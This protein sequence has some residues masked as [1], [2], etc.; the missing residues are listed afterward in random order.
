M[1][2]KCTDPVCGHHHA[3]P[4]EKGKAKWILRELGAHLPYTMFSAIA[5]LIL[6]AVLTSAGLVGHLLTFFH[7]FHPTHLFLS[8]TTTT[9]IFW[10]RGKPGR[11]NIIEA[12][13]IG[14]I[15][16][17]PFCT[18]SDI[19]FPY[20]AGRILHHQM[21]WHLC[22]VE[23]FWLVIPFIIA[24]IVAGMVAGE[25]REKSTFF[26]HS[27]HILVSTTASVLYL[28]NFGLSDWPNY[29]GWILLILAVSVLIPCC[30]GDIVFPMIF[31]RSKHNPDIVAKS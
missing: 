16:S 2:H 26:S 4:P 23:D 29:V 5:S 6:L 22:I 27:A 25:Y 9:A 20:T 10:S 28:I 13:L 19:V 14:I 21:T 7:L 24:G 12:A 11:F 31:I 17:V 30:L 1:E 3:P 8:A 18:L 15:G